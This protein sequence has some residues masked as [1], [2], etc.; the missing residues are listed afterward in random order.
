MKSLRQY[1]MLGVA[2]ALTAVTLTA[3]LWSYLASR[4][5]V[6]ELFDAQLAQHARILVRLLGQPAASDTPLVIEKNPGRGEA[7]AGHKYESKIA[8]QVVRPP[9][10][11][12]ARSEHM[13]DAPMAPL[14]PGFHDVTLGERHWR[15]FVLYDVPSGLWY[16][17]AE[18][19]DIRQELISKIALQSVLPIL[20]GA[21]LSLWLVWLLINRGLAPLRLIAGELNRRRLDDLQPL[22]VA[23]PNPAELDAIVGSIN[24]LFERLASAIERER[25]FAADAAHELK[26]PI[27]A[28]RLQIENGLAQAPGDTA[29]LKLMAQVMHLQRIVEQLLT[30]SRLEPGRDTPPAEAVDLQALAT[31]AVEELLETAAARR[32]D[33]GLE[34]AQNSAIRGYPTALGI[35]LRNL[36]HNAIHYTPEGGHITVR[37]DRSGKFAVLEVIDNGPGIPAPMKERAFDRFYRLGGDS[38]ASGQAGSGLGLAIAREI[39]RTHGGAISLRDNPAGSGLCAHIELPLAAGD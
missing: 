21:P 6:D 3:T 30:L 20:V 19:Y 36:V 13:P 25:R 9:A 11:L 10:R 27:A 2:G 34:V 38:H 33:L 16:F 14:L 4:E 15:V 29:L 37:V 39:V 8:F 26:T 24:R 7:G 18:R 32:Q 1:L 23:Q 28:A 31:R 17:S 5:E 22:S 35:L 12:L